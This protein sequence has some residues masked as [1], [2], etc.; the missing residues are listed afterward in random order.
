MEFVNDGSVNP[1][2]HRTRTGDALGRATLSLLVELGRETG[3]DVRS[4]DAADAMGRCSGEEPLE[5]L[6]AAASSAG[7]HV[8]PYR[9][10]VHDAVWLADDSAPFVAWSPVHSCWVAVTRHGALR[11]RV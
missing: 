5:L 1:L 9:L 11:A 8:T 4:A 6:A 3:S 7:L 2:P 10:S